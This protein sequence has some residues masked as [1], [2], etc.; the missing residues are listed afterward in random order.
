MLT[1]KKEI[2]K[3]MLTW[4]Y[5]HRGLHQKPTVPENSMMAFRR[6]VTEGFGI[7]FDIHLTKDGRLAVI[8]DSSLKRTCGVDLIIEDMTLEEAQVYFLEKS[9]EVI[10]DLREVLGAVEGKVPL[11]IELKTYGKNHSELVKTAV[12]ALKDY[13][14]IY[15][16]ESF[17]PRAVKEL[18]N[19]YPH[20]IRGQVAGELR[21]GGE[22]NISKLS[23]FLL[24]NLWVNL[25]G[26]PDFVAYQYVDRNIPA[27]GRFS[28]AKFLWTI[29]DYAHF[30]ECEKWGAAPIFEQFNPKDYY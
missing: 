22:G 26:K 21:K 14:G 30:S 9:E 12:E 16:L 19:S 6:A 29:R 25:M 24:K 4:Q 13:E 28:G 8:H 3:E 27:F 5:A 11:I 1:N 20:I 10:P 23:D 2:L 7:E 18:K 17:D 15:T